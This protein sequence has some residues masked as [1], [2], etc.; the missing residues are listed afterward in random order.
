MDVWRSF[1]F[2][3]YHHHSSLILR[4]GYRMANILH[5]REGL[6][7]EDP[8]AMVVYGNGILQIIKCLK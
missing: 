4:N 7:Q 1:C 8:L 5:S 6:T 3:F 2:Y